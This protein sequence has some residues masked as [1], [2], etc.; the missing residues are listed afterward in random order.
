MDENNLP[1]LL[2]PGEVARV[3]RVDPKTVTRWAQAGRIN[4]IKTPGG[5]KR[6]PLEIVISML[7]DNGATREE[8]LALIAHK[9][10]R[11]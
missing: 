1:Q 9:I 7:V 10:R 5:H 4:A 2:T 3:V 11:H 8:A 6:F